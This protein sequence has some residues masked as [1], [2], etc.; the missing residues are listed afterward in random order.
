MLG[1]LQIRNAVKIGKWHMGTCV[2]PTTT[3]TAAVNT[4]IIVVRTI[5]RAPNTGVIMGTQKW[6]VYR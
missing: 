1:A 5:S 4:P 6:T 3:G 2:A